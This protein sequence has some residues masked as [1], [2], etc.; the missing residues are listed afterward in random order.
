MFLR[1]LYF[2]LQ[3]SLQRLLNDELTSYHLALFVFRKKTDSALK[4]CGYP[5]SL[6]EVLNPSN[7]LQCLADPALMSTYQHN[8]CIL[9]LVL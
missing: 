7:E 8:R 9:P 2:K 4:I 3:V 6:N 5:E 1:T